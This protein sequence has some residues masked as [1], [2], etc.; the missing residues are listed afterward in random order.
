LSLVVWLLYRHAWRQR[1]RLGLGVEERVMTRLTMLRWQ[2]TL[3]VAL[4]SLGLSFLIGPVIK[5][6]AW[7]SLPGMIYFLM[8]F[9]YPIATAYQRRWRIEEAARE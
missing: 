7:V 2:V 9:M 6:G 8:V 4:V 5:R 1:D 3:L